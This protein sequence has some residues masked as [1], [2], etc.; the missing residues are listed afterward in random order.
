M[1][2][3]VAGAVAEVSKQFTEWEEVLELSE[4]HS[5]FQHRIV[6]GFSIVARLNLCNTTPRL[7]M[8][9]VTPRQLT[10][11]LHGVSIWSRL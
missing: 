1:S 8:L 11:V 5:R 4:K 9:S 10:G 2:R 3:E 6:A 7:R